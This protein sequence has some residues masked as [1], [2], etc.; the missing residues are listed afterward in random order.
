MLTAEMSLEQ[1]A[2]LRFSGKEIWSGMVSLKLKL[3]IFTKVL[4][5]L[6]FS[7]PM[8]PSD[9]FLMAMNNSN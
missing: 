4:E 9:L 1:I 3:I 8:R 6:I 5:D 7:T 2:T